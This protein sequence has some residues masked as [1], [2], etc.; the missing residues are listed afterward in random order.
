MICYY[1]VFLGFQGAKCGGSHKSNNA[2]LSEAHYWFEKW[3]LFSGW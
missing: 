3:L 1:V 2:P